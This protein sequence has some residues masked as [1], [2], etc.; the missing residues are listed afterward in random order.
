MKLFL[1]SIYRLYSTQFSSG[2]H[3]LPVWRQVELQ[4]AAAVGCALE[5]RDNG[6]GIDPDAAW[7]MKNILNS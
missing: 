5:V 2:F 6:R 7:I 3:M 1:L 4:E